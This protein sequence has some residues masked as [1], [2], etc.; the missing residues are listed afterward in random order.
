M[1]QITSLHITSV[2]CILG[3]A[4]EQHI[5]R[6]KATSNICTSQA[7]LANIAAMYAVYHGPAGLKRIAAKVHGFTQVLKAAVEKYGFV[8]INS[9]FFDTLTLD[10]SGAVQSADVVHAAASAVGINLRVVDDKSVGVTIDES[11]SP[12]ELVALINIFASASSFPKVSLSRLVPFDNPSIPPELRRTSSYL[13]YSVFNKHHSETE[14]LRY[15][16]HL[17]AKD[18]GL[19][20]AM[21]P[22]GSCTMKL[23]STSSMIPLTWPQF[24]N[25]HPFAPLDQVQGYLQVVKVY[26]ISLHGTSQLHI[27]LQELEADLCKITGFHACSLQPNSGAAGEYAGLSVIRAYHESRGESGR[28]VCLIPYTAHG[29]NPAVG[30]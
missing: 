28:D 29:T 5:R 13:E 21:I 17:A 2:S 14:M 7:L 20:H 19:I 8:A 22:L 16:N 27:Y 18:L 24:A 26:S 15:I 11:T 6:D 4:R 1:S 10:V 9:E 25:I 12:E 23:N 30:L 3:T